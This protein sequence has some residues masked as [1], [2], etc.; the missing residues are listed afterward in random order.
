M[1]L[2]NGKKSTYFAL[3]I[4]ETPLK[5]RF[6]LTWTLYKDKFIYCGKVRPYGG[7]PLFLKEF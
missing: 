2:K 5:S 6:F 7:N 4:A 3:K 1:C